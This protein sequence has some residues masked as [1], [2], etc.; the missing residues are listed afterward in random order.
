M[1][2][3]MTFQSLEATQG[4]FKGEEKGWSVPESPK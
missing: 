1:W 2:E 4:D 3:I